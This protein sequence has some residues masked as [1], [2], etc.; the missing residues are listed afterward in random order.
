MKDPVSTNDF[1]AHAAARHFK[2]EV[3]AL[4]EP[5]WAA[6]VARWHQLDE[7]TYAVVEAAY[8]FSQLNTDEWRRV[9]P[10]TIWLAATGGS[11]AADYDFVAN[12]SRSP[13][14][15]VGTLPSIRSS[16]LALM[17]NWRG[18]VM[19]LLSGEKTLEQGFEEM[20]WHLRARKSEPAWLVTSTR[21]AKENKFEHL[22]SFFC[23][24]SD[25][26]GGFTFSKMSEQRGEH[27]L[28]H[29]NLVAHCENTKTNQI[30]I[31]LG[32]ALVRKT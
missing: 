22:V 2:I 7:S 1:V 28:N 10:K 32:L 11:N 9:W 6:T 20:Y 18:P 8:R 27:S 13:S 3:P 31:G 21:I 14:R 17:M 15:F 24:G 4:I 25:L 23:F 19:C 29:L 16:S 12:G 30:N 26:E 5:V